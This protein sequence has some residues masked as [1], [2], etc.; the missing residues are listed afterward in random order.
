MLFFDPNQFA[1]HS[2]PNAHRDFVQSS[3]GERRRSIRFLKRS[4]DDKNTLVL[5]EVL[6]KL[7]LFERIS[8]WN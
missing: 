3:G 2:L 5:G 4:Y 7:L 8:K 6:H 1:A